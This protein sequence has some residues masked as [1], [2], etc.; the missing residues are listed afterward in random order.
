M[1]VQISYPKPHQ[2]QKM[3]GSVTERGR[4]SKTP[5]P[6]V[7]KG[8]MKKKLEPEE[9]IQ[10]WHSRKWNI[11]QIENYL[12]V[13]HVNFKKYKFSVYVL[14]KCALKIQHWYFNLKVKQNKGVSKEVPQNKTPKHNFKNSAKKNL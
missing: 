10:R 7:E 12:A 5:R 8:S 13:R 11:K 9:V 14:Q 6:T 2:I 4:V 1:K 3:Q